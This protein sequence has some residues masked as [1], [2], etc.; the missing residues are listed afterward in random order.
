MGNKYG[1]LRIKTM[2][3]DTSN[4]GGKD[5]SPMFKSKN[6]TQNIESNKSK[7]KISKIN[8]FDTQ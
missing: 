3:I 2:K 5:H 7:S 1:L 4:L 6:S 8:L